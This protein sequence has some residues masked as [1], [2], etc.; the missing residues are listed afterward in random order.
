MQAA[1]IEFARNVLKLDA[2]SQEFDE[3][4]PNKVIHIVDKWAKDGVYIEGS[5]KKLGGTMRLGS[6]PCVIEEN[7]LAHK[8]YNQTLIYERH[9]HRYEFNTDYL[10]AFEEVGVVF[11]G[12]SPDDKLVEII[13]LK[14]HPFFIA[15]QFHPEFQSRP[16][17][18][19]PLIKA[20]VNYSYESRRAK[21]RD[22]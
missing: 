8:I 18:P 6:Y 7:T 9:R 12:K 4:S 15:V 3:T 13:E 5:N 2:N 19:H 10:K 17:N 14:N 20:F 1:V 16:L 21:K 11:S 22:F